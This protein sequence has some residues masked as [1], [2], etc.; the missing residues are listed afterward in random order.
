VL[1]SWIVEKIIGVTGKF[2]F[3][4]CARSYCGSGAT[5]API[6]GYIYLVQNFGNR[7]IINWN[8][9][10]EFFRNIEFIEN[11]KEIKET[12]IGFN[13][14]L[15]KAGLIRSKFVLKRNGVCTVFPPCWNDF[16][17]LKNTLSYYENNKAALQHDIADQI[18]FFIRDLSHQHQHHEPDAD[19][20][21]TTQPTTKNDTLWS[22][23]V[24]YALYHHIIG[25]K[26]KQ[27]SLEHVRILG[28]LAYIR[29]FDSIMSRY[30]DRIGVNHKI[31]S[32]NHEAIKDSVSATKTY[33]DLLFA[34]KRQRRD[35]HRTIL[36]AIAASMIGLFSFVSNFGDPNTKPPIF[37]MELA[38]FLRRNAYFSIL[39]I[40]IMISWWINEM[41]DN[42]RTQLQR[43]GLRIG[44]G[45][46][47]IVA[48]L[49]AVFGLSII[50]LALWL[51]PIRAFIY[52]IFSD[53]M[54]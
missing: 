34:Q 40:I 5:D 26:R 23:Q 31:P 32:F 47:N 7:D 6:V 43:D 48:I 30:F 49:S 45:N 12:Y 2:E 1:F 9:N 4:L 3:Y 52:Q 33:L 10:L 25:A 11:Q 14:Q 36:F 29:S 28:I 50:G 37:V 42:R 51:M 17:L 16:E 41:F 22:D 19:T 13:T 53:L 20:I 44:L 54:K 21:I 24:F 8:Q 39:P 18:Y 27:N 38:N 15:S 46:R 35:T